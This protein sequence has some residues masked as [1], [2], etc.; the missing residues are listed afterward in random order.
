M[1]ELTREQVEF[2]AGQIVSGD[3]HSIKD[4]VVMLVEADAS[5]R[6]RLEGV[7]QER[8]TA[9]EEAAR[10]CEWAG[11]DS[12]SITRERLIAVACKIRSKPEMSPAL[13][14]RVTTLEAHLATAQARVREVE[15]ALHLI[16]RGTEDLFPPFRAFSLSVA[17]GIARKALTHAAEKEGDVPLR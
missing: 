1:T 7:E 8:D 5:L 3:I 4:H 6:S 14:D 9:Y 15:E 17:R 16:S 13:K 10:I 2:H 11:N 12:D